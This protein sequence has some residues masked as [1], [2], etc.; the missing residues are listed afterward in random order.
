MR[1]DWE[2]R[3]RGERERRRRRNLGIW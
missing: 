3:R 1:K 2:K